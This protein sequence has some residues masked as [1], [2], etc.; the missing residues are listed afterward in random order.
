MR[1]LAI[2]MSCCIVLVF[3]M[4]VIGAVTRLTESGLSMVEWRPLIGTLPPLSEQEWQRVFDLYRETPEY[5]LKNFWMD[6]EQ[7]KTIFFWE[8]FHRF[9][10]RIIG[11]AYGIPLLI[12]WLKGMIPVTYRLRLLGLFLLVVFQGIVGMV[13]VE[14]GLVDEPAVSHYKLATHL[15]LAFLLLGLTVYHALIFYGVKRDPDPAM[16]GY[17]WTALLIVAVTSVWGAFVAGRDAGLVYN[18]YPL[19]GGSLMPP[20]M[21]SMTPAWINFFENIPAIQFTHRWLAVLASASLIGLSFLAMSKG[22]GKPEF[23]ALGFMGFIQFGLGI[24][25]L[26]S[27][28]WLPVAVLHQAGAALIFALFAAAFYRLSGRVN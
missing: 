3:T 2:W 25:T 15:S 14:S 19:M 7:F 9:W 5:R 16:R 26:L 13:M 11:L 23:M 24:A 22:F 4:I 28:V 27:G 18:E 12:F 10:G 20:E 17:V 21:W 6:Q 1:V 8:W